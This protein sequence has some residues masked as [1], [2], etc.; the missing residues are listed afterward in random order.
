META[1]EIQSILGDLHDCDVWVN[2]LP[3]FLEEEYIQ[4]MEYFGHTKTYG[5]LKTGILYLQQERLEQREKLYKDF[6][7][8]WQE[9]KKQNI[10]EKLLERIAQSVSELENVSIDVE[11]F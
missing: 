9:I 10:W 4:A 7:N 5:R 8:F 11:R 3:Q 1:K 2:Y 6:L